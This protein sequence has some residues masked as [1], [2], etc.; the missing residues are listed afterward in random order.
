MAPWIC[1][2][3]PATPECTGDLHSM[4][5]SLPAGSDITPPLRGLPDDVCPCPHWG[6]VLK[7]RIRVTYADRPQVLRVGNLF[8]LPPGTGSWWKWTPNSWSSADQLS[9]NRSWT[10]LPASPPAPP[11]LQGLAGRVRQVKSPLPAWGDQ[12]RGHRR[13]HGRT[14]GTRFA[15]TAHGG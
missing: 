7:G 14:R 11:G 9:T 4:I 2:F 10:I 15:R 12:T 5:V 6:Y 3:I 8:H 1:D 13:G